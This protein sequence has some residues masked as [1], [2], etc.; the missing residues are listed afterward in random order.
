[1]SIEDKRALAVLNEMAK[2]V[3][4]HY[5]LA[6]PWRNV[7]PCLPNNR[8]VAEHRLKYLKRKLSRDAVL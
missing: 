8:L 6:I 2:L 1:M 5:Q 7:Q 3:D 4:G